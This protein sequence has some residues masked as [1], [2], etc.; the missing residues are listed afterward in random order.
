MR[1][2]AIVLL[3][4]AL[5][6]L[7]WRAML[8]RARPRVTAVVM[9]PLVVL[10]CAEVL[11]QREQSALTDVAE[12]ITGRDDIAVKCERSWPLLPVE[13]GNA[14]AY[15]LYP[16]GTAAGSS[17]DGLPTQTHLL[18]GTCDDLLTFARDPART[19]PLYAQS[20]HT[21]THEAMHLSGIVD[22]ADAECAAVQRDYG[23]ARALGA[24][25]ATARRLSEIYWTAFYP[26]LPGDYRSVECRPGGALDERLAEPP[27]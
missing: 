11:F 9:V 22:E 5:A 16:D 12:T 10:G 6:S 8:G 24:D 26:A 1:L 19:D 27:W 18:R 2:V 7:T 13:T 21:L 14:L 20:I 15:T 17:G 25:H 23:T 3:G 4:G